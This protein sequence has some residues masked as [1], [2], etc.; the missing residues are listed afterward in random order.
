M[1]ETISS[2]DACEQA[3][4][5]YRQLDYWCR[6]GYLGPEQKRW[7]SGNPRSFT[8]RDVA[9][10]AT[11]AALHRCGLLIETAFTAASDLLNGADVAE[12]GTAQITVKVSPGETL[13]E[14]IAESLAEE[15]PAA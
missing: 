9:L 2:M 15:V 11:A 6:T 14:L 1:T 13:A 10:V 5:T 4:I 12:V 7:G 8:I 3:G